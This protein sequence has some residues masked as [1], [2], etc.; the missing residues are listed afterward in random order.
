MKTWLKLWDLLEFKRKRTKVIGKRNTA[1]PVH[2][3]GCWLLFRT[4]MS[5]KSTNV[6]GGKTLAEQIQQFIL[7]SIS[8]F[9]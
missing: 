8:V 4:N 2:M 3:V 7:V 1:D 9:S 6:V 5:L